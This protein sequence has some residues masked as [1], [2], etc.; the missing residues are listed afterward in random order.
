MPQGSVH[1]IH[2]EERVWC[3]VADSIM[4][5]ASCFVSNGDGVGGSE[6]KTTL[7]C[8]SRAWTTTH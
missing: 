7:V 5:M 2:G 8:F 1:S 4:V 6:H 3:K